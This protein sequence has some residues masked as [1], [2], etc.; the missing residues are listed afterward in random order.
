MLLVQSAVSLNSRAA[1][2]GADREG[3]REGRRGKLEEGEGESDQKYRP[4][5]PTGISHHAPGA[6]CHQHTE[7][8]RSSWG[9][10][11]E[12]H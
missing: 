12:T 1:A 8:C 3:E 2:V 5:Q 11:S 7:T 6:E 10:T 4:S 9:W